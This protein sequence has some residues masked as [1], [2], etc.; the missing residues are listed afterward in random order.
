[1]SELDPAPVGHVSW[2][3]ELVT[4]MPRLPE[5]RCV[6]SDPDAWFPQTNEEERSAKRICRLCAE[7]Q[8]CLQ[9]A[10]DHDESGIW[11][12]TNERER[13]RLRSGLPVELDQPARYGVAS[14]E[15][16]RV[17]G[18]DAE[19][20]SCARPECAVP[21]REYKRRYMQSVRKGA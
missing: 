12:G 7:R 2:A 14:F 3:S 8:P 1:M 15:R 21:R 11:G 6:D 5:A 16:E 19:P 10:L 13:R 17:H 20:H 4:D 9:W 18:P